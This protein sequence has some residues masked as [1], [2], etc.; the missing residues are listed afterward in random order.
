MFHAVRKTRSN[1]IPS[2]DEEDSS[3]SPHASDDSVSELVELDWLNSSLDEHEATDNTRQRSDQSRDDHQE[4]NEE[5]SV[6]VNSAQRTYPFDKWE[7]LCENFHS[8]LPSIEELVRNPT[9][10]GPNNSVPP[11]DDGYSLF[12]TDEIIRLIVDETNKYAIAYNIIQNKYITLLE[13]LKTWI[14][15]NA[16]EIKMFLE[17]LIAMGYVRKPQ[18]ELYWSKKDIYDNPFIYENMTRDRFSLLL[19]FI[20]FS[21]DMYPNR[22][23]KIESVLAQLTEDFRRLRFFMPT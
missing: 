22:I 23:H 3:S 6:L 17:I 2:V 5:S 7:V 1:A 19:R 11:S 8:I 14:P 13:R 4:G 21:D 18:I 16:G 10:T 12:V 20:H 15:T 9:P